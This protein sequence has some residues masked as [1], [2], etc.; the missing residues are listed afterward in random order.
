M[1][2]LFFCDEIFPS[3]R[4][5]M[6]ACVFLTKCYD[7][8][9]TFI[10]Y[11]LFALPLAVS[12]IFHFAAYRKPVRT[13]PSL[14]GLCAVAIAVTLGGAGSI[15]LSEYTNPVSIYYIFGIGFGM[16]IAY[17]LVASAMSGDEKACGIIADI[18]FLSGVIAC[19]SII[20]IFF[21]NSATLIETKRLLD[22]Q[23]ANNLSTFLMLALPVAFGYAIKDSKFIPVPLVFYIFIVLTGSRGALL[24]GSIEYA[25][26][27]LWLVAA[28]KYGKMTKFVFLAA[29]AALFCHIFFNFANLLPASEVVEQGAGIDEYLFNKVQ[30]RYKLL[31]RAVEDFRSNIVF[32]R[33]LGYKGN[34]DIYNPAKGAMSW[35]HIWIAQIIGSMGL[36]GVAA[37]T[38]RFFNRLSVAV[39]HFSPETAPLI[40]SHVGLFL[41]SQ[42]NPGE[43]CPLPYA[44]IAVLIFAAV[45]Q[46]ARRNPQMH[47]KKR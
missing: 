9:D 24:M 46:S 41:M 8:F 25:V 11:K 18:I 1:L 29:H 27:I 7:S 3:F 26:C 4:T 12:V 38:Y 20:V 35:Y 21:E 36:V 39:K 16:V 43:F 30:D 10:Q 32:G 45:E 6:F 13:G 2:Q 44:L 28:S 31:V 34:T 37:F 42:V 40:F 5:L 33:G 47:L 22:F 19:F 14:K 17:L 23:S 15:S